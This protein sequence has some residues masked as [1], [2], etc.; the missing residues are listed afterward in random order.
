[1]K[2]QKMYESYK[3]PSG[4]L[5]YRSR[6]RL[7]GKR[8]SKTF[9]TLADLKFWLGKIE[10]VRRDV[11]L[12][13]D[14]FVPTAFKVAARRWITEHVEIHMAPSMRS[15]NRE[16]FETQFIP[17]IGSRDLRELNHSDLE[18]LLLNLM[19]EREWA[20]ATFNRRR[21]LLMSFYN[22]CVDK[23]I[24]PEN[25]MKRIKKRREDKKEPRFL[26]HNQMQSFLEA[27][28]ADDYAI[29]FY[30]LANTG[31]RISEA[32]GL[33]W[34]D[35]DLN[36]GWIR[37]GRIFCKTTKQAEERTKSGNTRMI[38]LNEALRQVLLRERLRGHSVESQD[39]IVAMPSGASP[40]H[41]RIRSVFSRNIRRAGLAH[42]GIHDLR[43]SFA[44]I[45]MMSG[46]SLW[47]LK[48]ILGHSTIELTE[49]YSHFSPNHLRQ[50]AE[51]VSFG[52]TSKA[53]L[54]PFERKR[55]EKEGE[56]EVPRLARSVVA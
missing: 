52:V 50:R 41:E 18:Q 1:M 32:L 4:E 12:G 7:N 10:K 23:G 33:R 43:H 6:V 11:R 44:S 49:R 3:N 35:V 36:G 51:Q 31:M 38:G 56:P 42:H 14:T 29:C 13:E 16:I 34:C 19:K 24:T 37:I 15:D 20:A 9:S 30:V 53:A 55:D 8:V 26:T 21:A 22:W 46:G 2:H 5:R 45:F 47:D 39:F 25:P 28:D 40:G 54:V 48:T 17:R 27:C